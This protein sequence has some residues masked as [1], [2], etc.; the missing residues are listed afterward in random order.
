[1]D[2]LC[3]VVLNTHSSSDVA[4][5]QNFAVRKLVSKKTPLVK[6]AFSFPV[7][8]NGNTLAIIRIGILL[9]SHVSSHIN[10]QATLLCSFELSRGITEQSFS[11]AQIQTDN[12]LNVCLSLTLFSPNID[13]FQIYC[14]PQ[15]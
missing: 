13:L 5:Q 12:K 15:I 2:L 7:I 1:M 3:W 4:N 10:I 14:C 9:G 8:L 11:N 6:E